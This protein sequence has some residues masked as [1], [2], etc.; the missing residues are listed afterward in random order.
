ML[1][2][3]SIKL[4]EVNFIALTGIIIISILL[5]TNFVKV[6]KYS[7]FELIDAD[8]YIN[9]SNNVEYFIPKDNQYTEINQI[10]DN[11]NIKFEK[12][13]SKNIYFPENVQKVWLK[14]KL[15]DK[16]AS[17]DNIMYIDCEFIENIQFYIPTT[18]GKYVKEKP[19]EYFIFPYINLP[20]NID[21]NRDIYINSTW[22]SNV[23]NLLLAKDSNFYII[24][25]L[26]SC[27]YIGN[28]GVLLGMLIMNMILFFSSR[29][30]KYL[31]HSLFTGSLLSL[32]FCLSGMQKLVLGFNS[33]NRLIALGAMAASTWVL[34][35]YSYLDIKNHMPILN[36][37]FKLSILFLV[38]SLYISEI[39][40]DG[41]T[42]DI[43]YLHMIIVGLYILISIYSYFK[44][45]MGSIYYLV[46]IFILFTGFIIY[47]LGSYGL[48]EWNIFAFSICYPAAS[49]E[50]LLFTIGIIKQIKH[51]KEV[52]NKLQLEVITD[53]LTN[54]YNRRY[55]EE[56]VVNKILQ[57]DKEKHLVS[58][59][60][61]DIDHFK[62]VNDTY[63]HSAGDLVLSETAMIIKQCLRKEDILVRWGGEEFVAVLPFT[64][65]KEST[66]IAE[67]IRLSIENH[68][69]K[70]VNKI[71]VSIGIAEK[72][73]V[74]DFHS[75]F[76]RAD[77]ALYNA[78]ENGRNAVCVCYTNEIKNNS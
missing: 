33:N 54:I 44:F 15:Q 18:D 26:L 29:D 76:R 75:W 28:L 22:D 12:N 47:I 68:K 60:V 14:L 51:E 1:K 62:K 32:L 40:P 63:G 41:F 52:N 30:K 42:Y 70:F 72:D 25:N 20:E 23:F 24:Q 69:F 59:L 19:N 67:T 56:T 35:I 53:K 8:K 46:G 27:F 73:I 31:F 74:E 49:I 36:N 61:L 38:L 5:L 13:N 57:L 65:S 34:F 16:Q 37:F 17:T 21:F 78:K 71:T 11:S 39:I 3:I 66:I 55:F 77:N 43:L 9:L 64:D 6:L 50:T 58:M 45:S 2:N 7:Y 4:K 48:L 10:A